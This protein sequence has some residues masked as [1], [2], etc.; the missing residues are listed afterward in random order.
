MQLGYI[1]KVH[2]IDAGHKRK[3]NKNAGHDGKH[4]HNLVHLIAYRSHVHIHKAPG[5]LPVN[6]YT[7][8][9]L[10]DMVIK[11]VYVIFGMLINKL[12]IYLLKPMHHLF[13][14]I[15]RAAYAQ[16]L[17]LKILYFLGDIPYHYC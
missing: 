15:D 8:C 6:I 17:T 9:Y 11:I 5:H 1:V 12:M 2:P 13:K 10:H 3:R 4:F 16:H 14:W 7:I